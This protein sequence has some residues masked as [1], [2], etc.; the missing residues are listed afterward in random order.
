MFT[1]AEVQRNCGGDITL[2][3]WPPVRSMEAPSWGASE[4]ATL[5]ATPFRL[6]TMK[7]IHQ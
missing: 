3:R 7:L 5:Y 1:K 2:D 4:V 6:R